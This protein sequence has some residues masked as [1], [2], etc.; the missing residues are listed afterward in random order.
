MSQLA[1]CGSDPAEEPD[2]E[3]A[4]ILGAHYYTWYGNAPG[5]HWDGG[6]W[7]EPMAGFYESSDPEVAARHIDWARQA[8]IRVFAVNWSGPGYTEAALRTGLLAARNLDRMRFCLFYDTAIRGGQFGVQD[9]YRISLDQPAFRRAFIEDLVRLAREFFDHPRYYRIGGRPVI[10]LYLTRNFSGSWLSALA[11]VRQ[12]ILSEGRSVY[13]IADE[14]W[15]SPPD[16]LRAAAFE[17]ISGYNP[18]APE[19][20][21]TRPSWTLGEFAALFLPTYELWH[22]TAFPRPMM[23]SVLLHYDDRSV[24]GRRNPPVVP[25]SRDE[26]KVLLVQAREMALRNL[27]PEERIVWVTTFNEW[28]EGTAVEPSAAASEWSSIDL[29]HEVYE[30]R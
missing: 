9:L 27:N 13:F 2:P 30:V 21:Q 26:A 4:V 10:W 19:T 6:I 11:E 20:M 7:R 3:P 23:P 29:L 1:G 25:A 28:H 15:Y 17:A 22:A 5:L 16:P 14:V 18:Y 24:P 8:G 12:R